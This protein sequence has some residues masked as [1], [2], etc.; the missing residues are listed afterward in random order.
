MKKLII[1][2]SVAAMAMGSNS[3]ANEFDDDAEFQ[4]QRDLLSMQPQG[5]EGKPWEQYLGGG[6]VDTSAYKGEGAVRICFSNAGIFNPWRVVGMNNME[7]EVELQGDNIASFR[8]LDAEG[9]DNKQIS[10]I[11]SFVA[12]GDCDVL[13]VSPNTTAAQTPAVE[14]ACESLPV[15]VF[16]RGVQ[17]DCPVTFIQPVG[18]YGFG[19]TSAEYMVKQLPKGSNVLAIRIMPG[20]DVL[21]TRYSAAARIFKEAGINIIGN[22]FTHSDRARTKA[23]VEDYINRGEQIDGL[24][25]DAGDT[26]TAA[27]EAFEDAGLD[28]PVVSGEDQ[29]DFLRMWKDKG[30]KAVGPSYPTYQWRT[31]ILAALAI[32][33]GKSVPGPVWSL[34]QPA[35]TEATL[36]SL[37]DERMPP[38]HYAL[39]GC[40]ELP[41]Y[42]ERWGGSK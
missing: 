36:D 20:V 23:T 34:P 25:L 7:G 37:V 29:M 12:S 9:N 18:G 11:E 2:A 42:P 3:V 17:T 15:V 39:C 27:L 22:E 1:L 30:L 13:I 33:A 28:Y 6:L 24:W 38:L 16:D 26:A 31:P 4:R 40:E 14:K 21:E 8:V 35:V 10:D 19:I 41:G 5:P 32:H